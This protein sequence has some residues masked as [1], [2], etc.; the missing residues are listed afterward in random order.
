MKTETIPHRQVTVLLL[1]TAWLATGTV[2][3]ALAQDQPAYRPMVGQP[4]PDF[5][6]PSIEDGSSVALSDFRGKKI[7]LFHFASW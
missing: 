5:S 2:S 3:L 7:L 6:L 1:L 4:H